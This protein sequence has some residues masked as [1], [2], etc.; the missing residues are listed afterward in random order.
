[1]RF[2]FKPNVSAPRGSSTTSAS[3]AASANSASVSG[4]GGEAGGGREARRKRRIRRRS[5]GDESAG[6]EGES[7][8]EIETGAAYT[9]MYYS[10][11]PLQGHL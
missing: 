7:S 8:S 6:T 3:T 11:T 2:K 5:R 1:M 10:G 9:F 4:V